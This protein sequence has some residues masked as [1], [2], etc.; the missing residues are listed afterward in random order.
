MA[1]HSGLDHYWIA[2]EHRPFVTTARVEAQLVQPVVPFQPVLWID[3]VMQQ[4]MVRQIGQK[5]RCP[6]P[7]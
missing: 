5:Q 7:S 1:F 4:A 2:I 6:S 3:L